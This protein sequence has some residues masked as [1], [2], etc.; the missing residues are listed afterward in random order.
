VGKRGRETGREEDEEKV[1]KDARKLEG[2]R[3]VPH[4]PLRLTPLARDRRLL[5]LI[6]LDRLL[7][8]ALAGGGGFELLA[9]TRQLR[10]QRRHFHFDA[11]K[12]Q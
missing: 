1:R 8:G 12:A 7:D 11:E 4:L 6:R 3:G 2:G 9:L 5:L 10:V